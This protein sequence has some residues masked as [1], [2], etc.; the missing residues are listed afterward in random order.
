MQKIS[1]IGVF[2]GSSAG[3]DPVY[4]RDAILL[5]YEMASRGITLIY[6]GGSIGLMGTIA[7][8]V[9]EKGGKAEG[10]IPQHLMDRELAHP[11][12]QKMHTVK[13]MAER[14]ALLW[15]LSD[16]FIA[17]PGGLGTMDE[18]FEMLTGFQLE[19]SEKPCALLNTNGYFDALISFL[20]HIVSEKFM[21]AE[22]RANIIIS[23]RP[24]E[25]IS[26]LHTFKVSAPGTNWI[27][28]LKKNNYY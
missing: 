9:L 6:G 17:L 21:R 22:H 11:G 14:K 1:T 7:D 20:D 13:D 15:R 19:I 12:I 26:L 3:I 23:Q 4:A 18:W 28:E 5:G 27:A 2:C 16:A 24:E 25:L 8:A 10:V